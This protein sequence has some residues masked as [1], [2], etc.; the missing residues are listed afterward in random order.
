MITPQMTDRHEVSKL[1]QYQFCNFH[2]FV[3]VRQGKNEMSFLVVLS[4]PAL[5]GYNSLDE[6][7]K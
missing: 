6:T 3:A 7:V 1:H 4:C 2:S 5:L